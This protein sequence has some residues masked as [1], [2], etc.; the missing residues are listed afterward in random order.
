MLRTAR[1][2]AIILAVLLKRSGQ[3]RA[4]V[5]AK[6]VKLARRGQQLKWPFIG[7]LTRELDEL[8]W[9]F[10]ELSSG[11]YGAIQTKTLESA[12]P[13][14]AKRWLSDAERKALRNGTLDIAAFEREASIDDE[15]LQGEDE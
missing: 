2:T 1:E 3:T 12:K 5:S 10:V 14:T 8:G 15:E 13:V 9:T 11:G 6:T 4:R 7:S